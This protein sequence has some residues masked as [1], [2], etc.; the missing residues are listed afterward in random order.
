[1]NEQYEIVLLKMSKKHHGGGAFGK[2]RRERYRTAGKIN[3]IAN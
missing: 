2:S 3:I 1:M